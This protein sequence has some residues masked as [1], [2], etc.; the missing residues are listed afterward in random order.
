MHSCIKAQ[1]ARI[2]SLEVHYPLY[3]KLLEKYDINSIVHETYSKGLFNAN[4]KVED[5]DSSVLTEALEGL[6]YRVTT[7]GRQQYAEG[8]RISLSFFW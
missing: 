2:K 3:S 1:D 7:L 4:I 5:G 8:P 6:G